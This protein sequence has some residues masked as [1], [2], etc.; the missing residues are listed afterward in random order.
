M[1]AQDANSPATDVFVGMSRRRADFLAEECT[2]HCLDSVI[3]AADSLAVSAV[4]GIQLYN[5]GRF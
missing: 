4:Q 2:K 3:A 5:R 1:K